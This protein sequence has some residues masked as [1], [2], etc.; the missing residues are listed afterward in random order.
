MT[1]YH[2]HEHLHVLPE[3]SP[4]LTRRALFRRAIG[5]SAAVATGNLLASCGVEQPG[6][7]RPCVTDR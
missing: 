5:L 7:Y 6:F 1:N 3:S 4:E 2:S